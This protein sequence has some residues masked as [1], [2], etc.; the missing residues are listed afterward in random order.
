MDKISKQ[1]Q[2]P[3]QVDKDREQLKTLLA[4]K[5]QHFAEGTKIVVAP[6]RVGLI[7]ERYD[8]VLRVLWEDGDFSEITPI[9]LGG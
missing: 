6:N 1:N 9:A 3:K 7:L 8:N 2:D 5:S 4:K